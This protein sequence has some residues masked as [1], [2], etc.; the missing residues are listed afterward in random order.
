MTAP[1]Y[2]ER[3]FVVIELDSYRPEFEILH[4]E[5][6]L[7]QLDEDVKP[8]PFDIG[9]L[10]YSKREGLRSGWDTNKTIKP[11]PV[12]INSLR[13]ERREL[14]RRLIDQ[15]TASG[16]THNSIFSKLRYLRTTIDWF[17]CNN[18]SDFAVSKISFLK[19]YC[20][21]VDYIFHVIHATKRWS[22]ESAS[23]HQCAS[24][25]LAETL[26]GAE[27]KL[28]VKAAA[29][30]VRA[31]RSSPSAPSKDTVS[32]YVTALTQFTRGLGRALQIDDFP[33]VIRV[34]DYDVVIYPANNKR[35]ISPFYD[36]QH[37]VFDP[38][39][40]Q[41]IMDYGDY[42][43]NCIQRGLTP[44]CRK[45]HRRS[46][47]FLTHANANRKSNSF[48]KQW[49]Q[50]VIRGYAHIIQ[51]ITGI[52]ATGL[53]N[54][55]YNNA[56]EVV[57]DSIK[58][59]IISIKFRAGGRLERYSIGGKKGL[60]L[61]KEYL[62]FRQWYL[63]GRSCKYLF[64]TDIDSNGKEIAPIQLRSDFQS[65]LFKQLRGRV[66]S[67]DVENVTPSMARKHKNIVLLRMGLSHSEAADALNHS[68]GINRS[69]YSNPSSDEMKQ[70]LF[71]YWS[72][73]RDA[74]SQIR[75]SQKSTDKETVAGHC[76]DFSHPVTIAVD[77]PIEP[78]CKTQYGCLFCKHY[79]C[80]SDDEDIRKLFS[81]KYVLDAVRAY[82]VDYERADFLFQEVS[83]R[84]IAIIELIKARYPER[85]KLIE[86]VGK[87]VFDLGLLTPF[88]EV[89]LQR[90]E[91]MGLVL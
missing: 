64:F 24:W 60:S 77:A 31:K 36:E 5:F 70:E 63:D 13:S 68:E 15:Y 72:S 18:L 76:D 49:A 67:E 88:W 61:L 52:N 34:V 89:R 3:P 33:L 87:E 90:Y 69:S 32:T 12:V 81:L 16:Q 54:I 86:K 79:A 11:R 53:V 35:I 6:T 41:P 46:L 62:A 50:K 19:A 27:F 28:E 22:T 26:F 25:A 80:H 48:R 84:I 45:D 21:Y 71:N 8:K 14:I 74:V 55:K 59:E 30:I 42:K 44:N 43:A 1:K 65:R 75:L 38:E 51:M 10:C 85:I 2:T 23:R 37:S 78:D 29:P 7:L 40:Y 39:T 20:A 58:N 83:V 91:A 47:E 56:Y 9:S 17:D 66:F 57:S 73:V 4:P 82:A